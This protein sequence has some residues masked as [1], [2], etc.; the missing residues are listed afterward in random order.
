[1]SHMAQKD[2]LLQS[3]FGLLFILTHLR[4]RQEIWNTEVSFRNKLYGMAA[5][6]QRTAE[7]VNR[8]G[9]EI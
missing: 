5:G 2:K 4:V 3:N 7:F 6:L 9:T 1:M 8:T